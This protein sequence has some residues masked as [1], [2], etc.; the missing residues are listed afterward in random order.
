MPALIVYGMPEIANPKALELLIGELQTDV[1][2]VLEI[3]GTEV[4]VF[5]PIDRVKAGLGEELVCVVEGMFSARRRTT[6]VRNRV[7]EAIVSSLGYFAKEHIPQC[8]KV[9]AIPN[10]FDQDNDGFA[11]CDPRELD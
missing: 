8:R 4:S 7:A 2:E 6:A 3:A 10:R 11:V 1:G 9:E 5:F